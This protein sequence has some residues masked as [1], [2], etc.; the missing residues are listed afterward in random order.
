MFPLSLAS[1]VFSS[2]LDHLQ[3]MHIHTC[4]NSSHLLF[5]SFVTKILE[6]VVHTC[7]LQFSSP[8]LLI[9][10]SGFL[11][12]PWSYTTLL[13]SVTFLLSIRWSVHSLHPSWPTICRR[14]DTVD[15]S[16]LWNTSFLGFLDP[17]SLG[18]SSF[19]IPDVGSFSC[20]NLQI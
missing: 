19:S 7:C 14:V 2:L 17:H 3:H 20:P 12:H 5:V 15:H 9:H 13:R 18:L 10:C 1:S 6:R 8:S 16:H 4:C 11:Y